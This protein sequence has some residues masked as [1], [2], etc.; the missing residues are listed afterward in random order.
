[1][2]PK[3]MFNVI[4][5][6]IVAGREYSVEPDLHLAGHWM[7][8]SKGLIPFVPNGMSKRCPRRV[9]Q[10]EACGESPC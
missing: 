2:K 4:E 1:M 9:H 8:L 6:P 5:H 7:I 3:G 10:Q